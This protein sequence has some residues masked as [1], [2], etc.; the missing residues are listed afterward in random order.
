MTLDLGLYCLD[1]H[2]SLLIGQGRSSTYAFL[3][4]GEKE[5]AETL[6]VFLL[7]HRG[8]ELRFDNAY[9]SDAV[10]KRFELTR[11]E[12]KVVRDANENL[13]EFREGT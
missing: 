11:E 13:A 7:K 10:D 2:E 5:F 4:H 12:I 9:F 3:W 8:H 1:C 6:I